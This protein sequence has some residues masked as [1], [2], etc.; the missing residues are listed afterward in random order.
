MTDEEVNN[1]LKGPQWKGE[2]EPP[3]NVDKFTGETTLDV[4]VEKVLEGA[5]AHDLTEVLIIGFTKEG[6]PYAAC[7]HNDAGLMLLHIEQT[8]QNILRWVE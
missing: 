7:S 8:K 5:K 4:P 3:A 2:G 1:V 6:K